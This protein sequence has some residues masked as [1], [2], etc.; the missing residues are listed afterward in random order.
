MVLCAA[1]TSEQAGSAWSAP[2]DLPVT[3]ERPSCC[4]WWREGEV[5]ECKECKAMNEWNGQWVPL[6]PPHA[7]GGQ[8]AI[9]GLTTDRDTA[10]LY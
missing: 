5:S 1:F 10:L 7:R 9:G 2:V 4:V 8:G 6:T 3:C